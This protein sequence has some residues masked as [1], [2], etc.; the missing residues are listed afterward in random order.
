MK[1]L[2]I[3]KNKICGPE[4]NT[5]ENR[6]AFLKNSISLA[7]AGFT[8]SALPAIAFANAVNPINLI[9]D[10][11]ISYKGYIYDSTLMGY[12]LGKR[13]YNPFRKSFNTPDSF[14]PFGIAGPNR[15]QYADGNPVN[16]QDYSGHLSN[17]AIAMIAVISVFT[18]LSA[19]VTFGAAAIALGGILTAGAIVAGSLLVVSG[20]T[21]VASGVLSIASIATEESNPE[22]SATLGYAALG[23]GIISM[24]TGLA[25]FAVGANSAST[26]A[27]FGQLFGQTSR[28]SLASRPAM[29]TMV[30][31]G[32]NVSMTGGLGDG[33][34]AMSQLV[35]THLSK[36]ITT[37]HK[38]LGG[39]A[40]AHIAAVSAPKIREYRINVAA[41]KIH[42]TNINNRANL[43]P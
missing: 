11:R 23:T 19:I 7:L 34:V 16:T 21:G 35:I 37:T 24:V 41:S 43:V 25:G 22:L 27:S 20:V 1:K 40:L 4:S 3:L 5:C 29:E 28:T 42:Q 13:H 26:S 15:F 31:A 14:S 17:G 38:A 39:V 36:N 6:R 8:Y 18:I 2:L 12:R 30:N 10:N 32:R 33:F 9:K